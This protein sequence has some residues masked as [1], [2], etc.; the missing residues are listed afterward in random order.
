MKILCNQ[1]H[2]SSFIIGKIFASSPAE[3]R[4]KNHIKGCLLEA[5]SL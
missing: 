1:L 5:F 4:R 2:G 3:G